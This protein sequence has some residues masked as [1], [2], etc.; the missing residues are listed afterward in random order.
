MFK[1]LYLDIPHKYLKPGFICTIWLLPIGYILIFATENISIYIG[2]WSG[3]ILTGFSSSKF[4]QIAEIRSMG[5][6]LSKTLDLLTMGNEH[7]DSLL[8]SKI[9]WRQRS[10]KFE[11][12]WS[13]AKE[14]NP[15]PE[16]IKAIYYSFV[17]A[18]ANYL[19]TG[20]FHRKLSSQPEELWLETIDIYEFI[21]KKAGL[22]VGAPYV[23]F[24]YEG[25]KFKFKFE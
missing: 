12:E 25:D 8:Q 19:K 6:V 2:V 4:N 3:L 18:Q 23:A 7:F 14:E 20:D 16:N 1:W 11:L 5:V 22:K 21:R 15:P 24:Y 10:D 9:V 13:R 17:T